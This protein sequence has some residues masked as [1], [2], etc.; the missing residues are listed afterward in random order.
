[1]PNEPRNRRVVDVE[2]AQEMMI[3]FIREADADNLELLFKE[4]FG[5]DCNYENETLICT[6]D[7]GC[8]GRLDQPDFLRGREVI[9][10]DP[11]PNKGDT[12][13]N[14]FVGTVIEVR[15]DETLC[16]E[17]PTTLATVKDQE[18]NC[19]DIES[20]RLDMEP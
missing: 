7:K 3:E 16:E 20:S 18:D 8:G 2:E 11:D 12:H 10:P 14:G 6:P 15:F 17:Y 4:I 9:V 1:M 13:N 19:F 5:Y